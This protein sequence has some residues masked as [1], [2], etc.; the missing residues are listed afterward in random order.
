MTLHTEHAI[1]HERLAG[2]LASALCACWAGQRSSALLLATEAR[3]RRSTRRRATGW[4]PTTRP[5]GL[6]PPGPEPLGPEPPGPE[7]PG[8]EPLGPE[9][10]GPGTT[11][12]L[13][14]R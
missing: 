6:E 4:R 8:P 3:P 5:P 2:A 11:A 10:R 12:A 7:S 1:S 9:L 13:P 14:R